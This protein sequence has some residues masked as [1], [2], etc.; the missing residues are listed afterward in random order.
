MSLPERLVMRC[1]ME[2]RDCSCFTNDR[3]LFGV[4]DAQTGASHKVIC[5]LALV[6]APC[7][8]QD[9]D[10]QGKFRIAVADSGR[11]TPKYLSLALITA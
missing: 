7:S 11:Y 2:Q 5:A 8:E 3:V 6:L 9:L 10:K 4:P 1:T